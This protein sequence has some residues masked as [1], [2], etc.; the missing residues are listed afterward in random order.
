M[1]KVNTISAKKSVLAYLHDLTILLAVILAVFLLVFR[2]VVVSGPSMMS[3]LVDGDYLI[4]VNQIFA[5]EP[6]QGDIVVISKADYDNGTPIIKRVIATEGQQ[7][8]IK[9]DK[10]FVDGVE[11]VEPYIH[12]LPTLSPNGDVYVVTVEPGCV[13][14]LGDNRIVSKDS[15]SSQI[16]QIDRREILGKAIF[17]IWPGANSSGSR[18]LGRVGGVG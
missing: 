14:V 15:R 1:E 11:L 3:T 7:V 18:D 10:V 2:I 13:F 9:D 8:I 17:C 16:G 5:G 6:K 12:G 4:V